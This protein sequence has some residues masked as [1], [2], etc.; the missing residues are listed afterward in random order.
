MLK[1][2]RVGG[3]VDFIAKIQMCK[4]I[5]L[6]CDWHRGVKDVFFKFLK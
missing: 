5:Q 2:F 3:G 4:K 6:W 1:N